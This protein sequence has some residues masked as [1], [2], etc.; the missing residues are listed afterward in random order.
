MLFALIF[1]TISIFL[2][3]SC[4]NNNGNNNEKDGDVIFSASVEAN[5]VKP[6][7]ENA[8]ELNGALELLAD[9]ILAKTN[10]RPM[11][12]DDNYFKLE[13]EIAVGETSRDVSAKAMD[14][15]LDII[16]DADD[17]ALEENDR[18]I[19]YAIYSNGKSVAIVWSDELLIGDA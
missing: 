18:Y 14:K 4:G 1:I 13:H 12:V 17:E 15:L 19:G 8:E 10:K 5:I 11:I 16:D 3:F 9:A 6:S 7:G 2:L